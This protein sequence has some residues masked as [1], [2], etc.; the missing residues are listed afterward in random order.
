L[1]LLQ[2]DYCNEIIGGDAMDMRTC[3]FKDDGC[4]YWDKGYCK[5]EDYGV[6]GVCPFEDGCPS[7]LQER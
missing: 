2:E 1:R 7:D 5:E 4:D 3:K 6:S